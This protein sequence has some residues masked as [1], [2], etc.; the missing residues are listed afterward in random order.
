[1]WR[2]N[3]SGVFLL[4]LAASFVPPALRG[5]FGDLRRRLLGV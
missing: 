5:V 2:R 1:M 3:G 4:Y